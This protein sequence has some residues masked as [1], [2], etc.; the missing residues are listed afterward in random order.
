MLLKIKDISYFL[1]SISYL[2]PLVIFLLKRRIMNSPLF[3]YVKI[4]ILSVILSYIFLIYY[5][6]S[7]PI[8]H[9][10]V[11]L[12]TAVLI[13][14]FKIKELIYQSVYNLLF[15]FLSVS[16]I[17]DIFLFNGIWGNNF[18]TTIYSNLCLTLLSLRQL[19]VILDEEDKRSLFTFEW[20]FY[21]T[22]SILILNSSSFFFSIFEDRIR[23][24][25]N[26]LFLYTFPIYMSFIFIHN[27]FLSIGLWKKQ[28]V[29]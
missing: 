29:Y 18:Y 5:S 4:N 16:F 2:F 22:V 10:S 21:I 1:A 24:L 19:F 12:S 9:F 7:F 3:F 25:E 14:Y 20:S 11:F 28:K 23:S 27:F 15:V 13:Y 8:F 6:N 17:I 26:N